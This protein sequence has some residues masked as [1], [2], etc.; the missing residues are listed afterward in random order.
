MAVNFTNNWKNILDKLE[1]VLETEFKGINREITTLVVG[2]TGYSG[3]PEKV[4][5][6]N[7]IKLPIK[8]ADLIAMPTSSRFVTI[9]H[10]LQLIFR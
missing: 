4:N 8:K 5:A 7:D 10:H 9:I 6:R 1:S 3:P 2:W